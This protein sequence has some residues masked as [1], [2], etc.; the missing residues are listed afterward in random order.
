MRVLNHLGINPNQDGLEA[1]WEHFGDQYCD[2][3]HCESAAQS[4]L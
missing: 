4:G 3:Q 2:Y 1:I